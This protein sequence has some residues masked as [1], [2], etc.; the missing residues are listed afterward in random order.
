MSKKTSFLNALSS[1]DYGADNKDTRHE[2]KLMS[3][4]FDALDSSKLD[5]DAKCDILSMLETYIRTGNMPSRRSLHPAPKS[6]RQ[7]N[8]G[9]HPFGTKLRVKQDADLT[10]SSLKY[11][12]KEG[13]FSYVVNGEVFIEFH[14]DKLNR[15]PMF[16]PEDLEAQY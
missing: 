6:W 12:G 10:G 4:L 11:R 1:I 9:V 5:K 16:K 2:H 3:D 15:G 7:F 14:D 13:L 8:L